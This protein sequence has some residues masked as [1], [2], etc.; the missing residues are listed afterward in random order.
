[1]FETMLQS[2]GVGMIGIGLWDISPGLGCVYIGVLLIVIGK[3]A[4]GKPSG[5]RR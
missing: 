1:M 2:I 3:M 4:K 5:D